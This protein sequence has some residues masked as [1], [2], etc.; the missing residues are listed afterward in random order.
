[1]DAVTLLA[2]MVDALAHRLEKV[3]SS[4]SP[5]GSLE[6][7]VEVYAIWETYGVQGHTSTECYNGPPVI[8]HFNAFQGYQPLP[9]HYSHL[10]AY[11]QG[12][13]SHSNPPYT[14]PAPPQ[15]NAMRPL[16]F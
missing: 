9:H 11:N 7:A 4:P 3:S 15:Q 14:T 1:M 16:G 2:S 12:R 13:K 5:G 10:T 6:S 8:E